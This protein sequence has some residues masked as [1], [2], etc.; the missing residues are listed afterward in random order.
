M[1]IT[2]TQRLTVRFSPGEQQKLELAAFA[3]GVT[4]SEFIRRVSVICAQNV[5]E[6]IDDKLTQLE[7]TNHA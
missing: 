5:I 4:P 7:E 3:S 1:P 6:S 2:K